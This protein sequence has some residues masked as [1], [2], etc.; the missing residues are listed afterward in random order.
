[1]NDQAS[2]QQP[3]LTQSTH[4]DS[5]HSGVNSNEIE[6]AVD[7]LKAMM[8]QVETLAD[9]MKHWSTS[10]LNLFRLELKLNTKA[11]QQLMLTGFVFT[12]LAILFIVSF[13]IC[14]GLISYQLSAN[15]YLGIGVFL[16]SFA[17]VLGL[18]VWWQKKLVACLG[19]KQ[20]TAQ[21]KEGIHE[22]S[23]KHTA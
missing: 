17:I 5:A 12:L 20:T 13:C 23:Q 22:L 19:F 16:S 9:S 6:Q 4:E 7:S 15:P 18:L 8:V 11:V 10:T 3:P 21:I 2:N 1:M 14:L